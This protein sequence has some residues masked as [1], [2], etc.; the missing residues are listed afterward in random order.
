MADKV[1]YYLEKSAPE[2]EDLQKKGIFS[3]QEL[4]VIMRRRTEFEHRITGRHSTVRDFLRYAEYEMNVE[5]LRKK[6]VRRLKPEKEGISQW[7][8]PRRILFIFDRATQKFKGDLSLWMQYLNYARQQ[9]SV[10]VITKIFTQLL[11]LNP[12]KPE[13]WI[14][15]AKYEFEHNQSI[16][17]ARSIMQRGLR[18]N[19]DSDS[20]FLEYFKLEL[21]FVSKAKVKRDLLDALIDTETGVNDKT[22]A[23]ETIQLP[24]VDPVKNMLRNLPEFDSTMLSSGETPAAQGAIALAVYDSAMNESSIKD[25]RSFALQVLDII[26]SFQDLDRH[27]LSSHVVNDLKTRYPQDE[28]I[29]LSDAVLPIRNVS[30]TDPQFPD[31]L[32]LV[33]TKYSKLADKSWNLKQ[34]FNE[35]MSKY[36]D[37]S[38]E[39]PIDS[40]LK[41]V[42]ERITA[43]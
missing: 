33:I 28:Y 13:V 9:K 7:A 36:L 25:K 18:F 32:K 21:L 39:P 5:R 31:L 43:K 29:L 1:R 19:I 12:T 27:Y 6:R 3:K 26:D 11:S 37:S 2:L 23:D 16:K 4:S 15:A 10:N 35:Y 40:S 22:D 34:Q 30:H 41:L 17:A 8:G 38:L 14:M 24:E 42:I 20:L